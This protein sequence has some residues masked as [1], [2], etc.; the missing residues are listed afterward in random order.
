MCRHYQVASMCCTIRGTRES[1]QPHWA[2]SASVPGDY[3]LH[4][5]R[6]DCEGYNSSDDE[7]VLRGSCGVT[8]H[9][10]FTHA[11]LA[12]WN[13]RLEEN[14]REVRVACLKIFG[15]LMFF[16]V[17]SYLSRGHEKESRPTRRRRR[18]STKKEKESRGSRHPSY[19]PE[20]TSTACGS[21]SKR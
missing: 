13:E 16:C 19:L 15:W 11:G 17:S 3:K 9:V 6:I 20:Y 1:G 8:Y 12:V 10:Q 5:R 18:S 14:D 21:S 2:C 4:R 7:A